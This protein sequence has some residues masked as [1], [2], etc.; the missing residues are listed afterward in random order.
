M[1]RPRRITLG[2]YVYHV[3]D[4][5]NGRLRIFRKA[6]DFL[7]FERNGVRYIFCSIELPGDRAQPM[8]ESFS[9]GESAQIRRSIKRG[10]PLGGRFRTRATAAQ[11]K[12][13]ATLRRRGRPGK[14]IPKKGGPRSLDCPKSADFSRPTSLYCPVVP[15]QRER[16]SPGSTSRNVPPSFYSPEKDRSGGIWVARL[17]PVSDPGTPPR[18][19]A[20][21][22]DAPDVLTRAQSGN[23]RGG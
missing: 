9:D 5:A 4:R 15:H 11:L 8:H 20:V 23:A 17:A 13:E 21:L 19:N 22:A 14:A 3:L 10:R 2:W 6:D 18:H 12:L 16:C 1:A 7:A